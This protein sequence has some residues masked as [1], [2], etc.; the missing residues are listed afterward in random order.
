MCHGSKRIKTLLSGGAGFRE[1]DEPETPPISPIPP[2][3][4]GEIRAV[5]FQP[6]SPG[7]TSLKAYGWAE[8]DGSVLNAADY[9]E[10]SKVLGN[11]WGTTNIGATFKIPDLRGEFLRGWS[12]GSGVDPDATSRQAAD[13]NNPTPGWTGASGDAVGS[14]QMD[15]VIQHTHPI[16]GIYLLAKAGT[17]FEASGLSGNSGTTSPTWTKDY[18][19]RGVTSGSVSNFESRPKNVS[20]MYVIYLGKRANP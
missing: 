20:V 3:F 1:H 15:A 17:G 13:P 5:S 12:H 6:D 18:P 11:T 8:C 19:S 9:P 10:L 16:P 2:A 14:R 4:V 7:F